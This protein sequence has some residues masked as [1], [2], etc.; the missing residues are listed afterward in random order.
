[1]RETNKILEKVVIKQLKR[2]EIDKLVPIY[3][4]AFQGMTSPELAKQWL[5]CNLRAF[6]QKICF[7]AWYNSSLL[8]YAV[9]TEKGG[10]RVQAVWELEQIAVL[11]EYRGRGIG[12]KLIH[13][14]LT[15]IKDYLKKR[16]A[17]L[18]LVKVTTGVANES[19]RLY[20]KVLGAKQESIVRDFYEGDEQIMIARFDQANAAIGNKDEI[21]LRLEYSE[22]QAGY[23]SRDKMVPDE[24]NH[25]GLIFAALS[26]VLIFAAN[27]LQAQSSAWFYLVTI[28][29]GIFG[30]FLLLGFL[31]D[32][33][34]NLSCK[35][36]LRKRSKEIEGLLSPERGIA[37]LNPSL[38]IW[39]YAIPK[40]DEFWEEKKLKRV[41]S[42]V[43]PEGEGDYFVWAVRFAIILWGA[44]VVLS[45]VY[46]P[47][48]VPTG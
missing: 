18:K 43:L 19:R 11:S 4:D 9:W 30:L 40:R 44:L 24:V 46:G 26:A 47:K 22:C 38:S 15:E 48:I 33:Q 2:N 23:N 13:D 10:F 25:V 42:K 7:G 31:T 17:N 12:A 39:R 36:A 29:V 16:R 20:E 1:M 34:S 41:F 5:H 14:S 35:R 21:L 32:I 37:N 8:G 27:L 28:V 3:L 6:P 45:I